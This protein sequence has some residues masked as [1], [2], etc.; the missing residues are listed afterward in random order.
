MY[1]LTC[2]VKTAVLLCELNRYI[3]HFL[4]ALLQVRELM[5]GVLSGMRSECGLIQ[6]VL[7][8]LPMV[9]TSKRVFFLPRKRQHALCAYCAKVE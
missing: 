5:Q 7:A 4:R 9:R 1:L 8:A 3:T 2:T 6:H